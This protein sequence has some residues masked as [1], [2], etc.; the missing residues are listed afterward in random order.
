MKIKLTSFIVVSSLLTS[1]DKEKEIVENQGPNGKWRLT[2]YYD[3]YANGGSFSWHAISLNNSHSLEFTTNGQYIKHPNSNSTQV[4][5]GTFRLLSDSTLEINSNC[6]TIT[7]RAKITQLTN[8]ILIIDY[9][10]IEGTIR[11][12]YTAEKNN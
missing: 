4:C 1:C 11:Y 6:Q 10:V 9:S 7:E 5:S 3:G 12:K 2:E 8:S